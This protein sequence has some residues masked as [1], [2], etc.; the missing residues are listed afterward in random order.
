MKRKTIALLCALALAATAPLFLLGCGGCA[1]N[2][3]Q[4]GQT[5]GRADEEAATGKKNALVRGEAASL[6]SLPVRPVESELSPDA[7]STYAYLLYT[8]ALLDEDEAALLQAASLLR[9]SPVPAKVWMEGGVWLMSRKSPNAVIF[10]EQALSAWPE[11]MSLN[12]LY[13]EA[14]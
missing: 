1:G 6:R 4:S 9:A 2:K 12:L 13:A 8:Q 11:D 3:P 5:S 14:L 7:Q 10:L